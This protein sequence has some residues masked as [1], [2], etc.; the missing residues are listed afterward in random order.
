MFQQ[1]KLRGQSGE[2][3]TGYLVAARLGPWEYEQ[4]GDGWLVRAP[5]LSANDARL[6]AADTFT[7]LLDFP[8]SRQRWADVR[9]TINDGQAL[10]TG[11]SMPVDLG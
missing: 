1:L 2:L 10:I 5:V 11:S 8:R 4:T 7:L 3:R 9:A 6:E